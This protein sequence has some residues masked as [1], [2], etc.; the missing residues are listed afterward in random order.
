M[1]DAYVKSIPQELNPG[2]WHVPY[3]DTTRDRTTGELVYLDNNGARISMEDARIISSSCCAQVS[4]RKNDDSFDKAKKIYQ[5]LIESEPAHASPVEHQA[6]P[7]LAPNSI[8]DLG[9]THIDRDNRA[10]SG[11][12]RGWVQHRKL[13]AGE[14][15]W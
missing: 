6:T 5:Q 12:L 4:Y 7:M 9:T 1:R 10:W 14:A 15:Q 3:V 2:E 8:V 13:I 11:N